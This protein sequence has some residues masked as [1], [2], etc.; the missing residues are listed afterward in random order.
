ME[1]SEFLSQ[2]NDAEEKRY[3]IEQEIKNEKPKKISSFELLKN[4]NFTKEWVDVEDRG[5]DYVP[6]LVN[7]TL[8]YG[9]DTIMFAHE[10]NCLPNVDKQF[11]FDYFINILRKSKR[12]NKGFDRS[13][14]EVIRLI[15]DYY[16]YTYQKSVEILPILTNEQIYE[17]KI[18]LS[19]E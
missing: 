14:D 10:M 5:V 4:I 3:Q 6:F 15:M 8:S 7:R 1:V 16:D 19:K 9:R 17:I 2:C 18:K 13:K 11:N 12:F